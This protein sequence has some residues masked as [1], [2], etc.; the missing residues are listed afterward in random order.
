[1]GSD[2]DAWSEELGGGGARGRGPY[3]TVV[4]G[5]IRRAAPGAARQGLLHTKEGKEENDVKELASSLSAAGL[6]GAQRPFVRGAGKVRVFR[7]RPTRR[8]VRECAIGQ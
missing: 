4:N 3:L 6:A 5:G 1:M 8:T 2:R 7:V